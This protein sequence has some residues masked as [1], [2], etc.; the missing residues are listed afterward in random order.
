MSVDLGAI[1]HYIHESA[2]EYRSML[3]KLDEI[4]LT[5]QSIRTTPGHSSSI[6]LPVSVASKLATPSKSADPYF[7]TSPSLR[8]SQFTIEDINPITGSIVFDKR[9]DVT[10]TPVG[11]NLIPP[12]QSPINITKPAI[13]MKYNEFE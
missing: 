11:A 9:A 12:Y 6:F 8:T 7:A 4:K 10:G 2:Q 5:I 13:E 1:R 3:N